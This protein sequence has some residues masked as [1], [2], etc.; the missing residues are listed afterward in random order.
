MAMLDIDE[1]AR[2]KPERKELLQSSL[3]RLLTHP[4]RMGAVRVVVFGSFADENTHSKGDLDILVVVPQERLG[5]EWSRTIIP[6]STGLWHRISWCSIPSC[7]PRRSRPTCSFNRSC[8]KGCRFS[9]RM[10][11]P[12][13]ITK[14]KAGVCFL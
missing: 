10:P 14:G 11:G 6:R 8:R 13:P 7:R 2:R 12:E 4:E 9:E 3:E 5:R 1:I